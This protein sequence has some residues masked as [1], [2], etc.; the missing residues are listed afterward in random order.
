M[1]E[2][3]TIEWRDVKDPLSEELLQAAELIL[4]VKFP[5][6]YRECLRRYH[7]AMPVVRRYD[8]PS[9][10]MGSFVGSFGVLLSLDLRIDENIFAMTTFSKDLPQ[11][12]SPD[13]DLLAIISLKDHYQITCHPA[14]ASFTSSTSSLIE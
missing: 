9:S 14:H 7:G 2:L 8:V 13:F 6:D 10:P 4:G 11:G 3:S 1:A 12:V 5:F